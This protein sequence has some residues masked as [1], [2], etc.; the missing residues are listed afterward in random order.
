M[1]TRSVF[2]SFFQ[3]NSSV[4][5]RQLDRALQQPAVHVVRDEPFAEALQRALRERWLSRAQAAEDHLPT[6][7]DNRRLHGF[8][9]RYPDVAL[10]Q[11]RHRQQRGGYRLL[12][13]ARVAV[14]RLQLRLELVVEQLVPVPAQE[15]EQLPPLLQPLQHELLLPRHRLLRLPTLHRHLRAG[16]SPRGGKEDHGRMGPV[17]PPCVSDGNHGPQPD[18][19]SRGAS[20]GAKHGMCLGRG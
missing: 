13:G 18:W 5:L 14:H 6:Q 15:A 11:E 16:E 8:D 1:A 7:V 17:D 3:S 19:C 20:A 12:A 9:V 10:E 2:G 4:R